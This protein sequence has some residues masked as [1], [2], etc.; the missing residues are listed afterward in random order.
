MLAGGVLQD[1][2]G[3]DA[4]GPQRRLEP[5]HRFPPNLPVAALTRPRRV[6]R[7]AAQAPDVQDARVQQLDAAAAIEGVEALHDVLGPAWGVLGGRI[8]SVAERS[9]GPEPG[10]FD[11]EEGVRHSGVLAWGEWDKNIFPFW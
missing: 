6:R 5:L 10:G 4:V 7:D 11:R 1:R 8:A 2:P 3:D 9:G